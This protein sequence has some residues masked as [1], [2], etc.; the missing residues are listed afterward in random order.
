MSRSPPSR[1]WLAPRRDGG[2]AETSGESMPSLQEREQAFWANVWQCTHRHPCKRCCWPWRGNGFTC[3]PSSWRLHF[4]FNDKE[5]THGRSLGVYRV[6]YILT[7]R[8]MIFPGLVVCHQCAFGPCCNPS[9]LCLGTPSDNGRDR[10]GKSKYRYGCPP[11]YFPNGPMI[12]PPY[13]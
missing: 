3:T 6:A 2:V 9:H 8:T 4:L 5:I 13:R 7:H 12:T 11:I 1:H 10:R